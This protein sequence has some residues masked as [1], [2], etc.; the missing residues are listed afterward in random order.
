MP[1]FLKTIPGGEEKWAKAKAAADKQ[2]PG[3]KSSDPD[4]YYAI[5]TAITKKM[6]HVEGIEARGIVEHLLETDN[7]PATV[8]PEDYGK[9]KNCHENPREPGSE[10]CGDC[11][12]LLARGRVSE[13]EDDPSDA[14]F[15]EWMKKAD[16]ACYLNY[17]MS[18]HDL[19]DVPFR[20]WFKD[21]VTPTRAAARAVRSATRGESIVRKSLR[22]D[23]VDD[24]MAYEQGDLSDENTIKLF[25]DLVDSGLAWN[26]QG[27]YGRTAKALI[28]QGLIKDTHSVL[29]KE[30]EE[31]LIG[32]DEKKI[33]A[34]LL[35]GDEED[36][37]V[38]ADMARVGGFRNLSPEEEE[39]FR[40]W[41]RDNWKP[42][43]P[44]NP[45]WHPIV[46]DEI[47]KLAG[48]KKES[49]HK[50]L[51]EGEDEE[52]A[53]G[54]CSCELIAYQNE[55][56][57]CTHPACEGGEDNH[58]DCGEIVSGTPSSEE[59]PKS[60]PDAMEKLKRHKIDH[61]KEE[62]LTEVGEH[63]L[64]IR[65]LDDA[66]AECSQGDWHYVFTGNKSKKNI[67]DEFQLHLHLANQS[68]RKKESFTE[69]FRLVH[70]ENLYF[71][72]GDTLQLNAHQSKLGEGLSY[73][74]QVI[75]AAENGMTGGWDVW[76]GKAEDGTE[77]SFYGFSVTAISQTTTPVDESRRSEIFYKEP[78]KILVVE[79]LKD[80]RGIT[81]LREANVSFDKAKLEAL[82]KAYAQAVSAKQ[83]SFMFEGQ[84]LLASYAKYLIE[85][86]SGKLG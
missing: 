52:F 47:K 74:A 67:E 38:N 48:S 35:E 1:A 21:G 79:K 82:K 10:L 34:A 65:S 46:R 19:P 14:K 64:V 56:G 27:H 29:K 6:A 51:R 75:T 4:S 12:E 13:A 70:G 60:C 85:Y 66:Q 69:D 77:V 31:S 45:V 57:I 23:Q 17:G 25:Q 83:E 72:K 33:V 43:M 55:D 3:K 86:L 50:K 30:K 39:R 63:T 22:E 42:G 2:Y 32:E 61:P 11:E 28:D 8:E 26:L 80:E 71:S 53:H 73:P 16:D 41:A 7:P 84:E 18:I 49:K 9:C 62:S 81:H 68:H 59:W 5:V 76:D 36:D 58:P 78:C 44:N 24:I 37:A 20:D 15:K 40:Q 54:T